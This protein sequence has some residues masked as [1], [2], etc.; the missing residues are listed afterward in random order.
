MFYQ[1]L[2]ESKIM[3]ILVTQHSKMEEEAEE[4]LEILTSQVAFQIFL[5][6]FLERVL[7]AAEDLDDQTI[8]VQI[9][10]MIYL[11]L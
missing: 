4:D 3:I 7:V 8:E 11:S 5:K 1:M 9:L 10:D 2:R 6:T